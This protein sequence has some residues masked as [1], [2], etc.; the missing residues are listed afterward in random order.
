MKIHP[1]ARDALPKALVKS[2]Q[3]TFKIMKG[4]KAKGLAKIGKIPR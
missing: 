4:P 3:V 2:N 1:E